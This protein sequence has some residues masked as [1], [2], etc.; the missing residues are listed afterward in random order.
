[1]LPRELYA[2]KT[3]RCMLCLAEKFEIANYPDDNILNKRT[4]VIAKCRH[5]HL[6]SLD[7][8]T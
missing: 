5:Q 3:R 8:V 7:N 4:E 6:A 2:K 1:M